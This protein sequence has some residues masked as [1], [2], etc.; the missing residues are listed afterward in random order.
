MVYE[1]N[2]TRYEITYFGISYRCVDL[3][4]YGEATYLSC[5]TSMAKKLGI[6]R[7]QLVEVK[8]V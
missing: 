6:K 5:L 1:Y 7:K 4:I 2:G 8:D 3:M